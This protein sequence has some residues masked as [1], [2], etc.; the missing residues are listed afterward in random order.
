MPYVCRLLIRAEQQRLKLAWLLP[1]AAL[2]RSFPESANPSAIVEDTTAS[3]DPCTRTATPGHHAADS[4]ARLTPV[5]AL[6]GAPTP[7]RGADGLDRGS[8]EPCSGIHVMARRSADLALPSPTRFQRPCRDG[9]RGKSRRQTSG[10]HARG[11]DEQHG[12]DSGQDSER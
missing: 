11:A 1:E 6:R 4:S 5:K 7:L 9:V 2:E 3:A 10:V 8:V 12:P